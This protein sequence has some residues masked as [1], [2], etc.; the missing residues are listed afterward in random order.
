MT[1]Y[2]CPL[3]E[4]ESVRLAAPRIRL[5]KGPLKVSRKFSPRKS[6]RGIKVT[7]VEPGGFR[8]DF[9]G[10]STTL[11]SGRPEYHSTVGRMAQ[12]QRRL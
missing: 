7:V 1:S 4:D 3:W 5:R 2:S 11:H 6:G 8:T 9:A 10:S 12:F